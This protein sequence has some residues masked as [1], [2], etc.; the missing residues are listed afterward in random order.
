M[1]NLS[2]IDLARQ[3]RTTEDELRETKSYI[4]QLVEE[5]DFRL[6]QLYG[7][8]DEGTPE[9]LLD[10]AEKVTL[11]YVH[12]IGEI[13][14]SADETFDPN[15]AWGGTWEQVAQGRTLFGAGTLNGITYTA[16]ETIDAGLPNISGSMGLAYSDYN[17]GNTNYDAFVTPPFYYI[18]RSA[19][20]QNMQSGTNDAQR[21]W[22]MD[23]STQNSIY[24]NSD[25][26][27]PPALVVYIWKRIA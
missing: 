5:L 11:D 14:I 19:M 4:Y 23:A 24:G 3:Y 6:G 27:Q 21:Q 12:P 9:G 15:K 10:I 13:F 8:P 20:S 26:V 22:Y 2:N 16:G 25:T 7:D 17:A 1:L 18:E